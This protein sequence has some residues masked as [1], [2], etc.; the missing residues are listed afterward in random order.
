[1]NA[2][3]VDLAEMLHS[4]RPVP[5]V[6][7]LARRYGAI[8]ANTRAAG[9]IVAAI[10]SSGLTLNE[11]SLILEAITDRVCPCIREYGELEET[12]HDM[13][14]TC[15]EFNEAIKKIDERLYRQQTECDG[16]T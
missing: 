1:M 9:V 6:P 3:L 15:E 10:K 7:E 8:P 12:V 4:E 11:M 5:P 13:A 2:P 16:R 14:L